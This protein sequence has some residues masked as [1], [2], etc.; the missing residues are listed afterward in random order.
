M[1]QPSRL[2]KDHGSYDLPPGFPAIPEFLDFRLR[3]HPEGH[4]GL[5]GVI[6]D[7]ARRGAVQFGWDK[8]SMADVAAAADASRASI[9][10]YFA[11]RD[12]LWE[13]LMRWALDLFARD[14]SRAMLA[15]AELVDKVVS[16]VNVARWYF[17]TARFDS[18]FRALSPDTYTI[19]SK[20]TLSLM[21]T[22]MRPHV[23][24][25]AAAGELGR[26]VD[27]DFTCEWLARAVHTTAASPGV[28]YDEREPDDVARF[29]RFGLQPL[30]SAGLHP[31]R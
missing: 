4:D 11:H 19:D 17:D 24:A 23:E 21:C 14:L 9:Y 10:K 28:F 29:L 30:L 15:P 3:L 18:E 7:A 31:A 1:P 2:I 12:A 27:L 6:L 8:V 22:V 5:G 26:G 25:A 13:A 16:A 20:V